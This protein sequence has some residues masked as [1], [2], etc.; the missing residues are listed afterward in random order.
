MNFYR[1]N[2]TINKNK[3]NTHSEE[4]IRIFTL[5]KDD[6]IFILIIIRILKDLFNVILAII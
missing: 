3:D 4:T 1:Y 2:K 6:Y 5:N